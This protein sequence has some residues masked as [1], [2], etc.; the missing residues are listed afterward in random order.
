LSVSFDHAQYSAGLLCNTD[1]AQKPSIFGE[2]GGVDWVFLRNA[3]ENFAVTAKERS[4]PKTY[5]FTIDPLMSYYVVR[6]QDTS[7]DLVTD[8]TPRR[9]LALSESHNA[10]NQKPVI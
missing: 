3:G 1:A 7:H 6:S 2:A 5:S 4:K 9:S 8:V 10:P